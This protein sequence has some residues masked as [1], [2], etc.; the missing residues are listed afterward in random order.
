[1]S[2]ILRDFDCLALR[3]Q[4]LRQGIPKLMKK[5]DLP[6]VTKKIVDCYTEEEVCKMLRVADEDERFLIQFLL[7]TGVRN[8]LATADT[9]TPTN[10]SSVYVA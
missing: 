1:M 4:G 9:T 7:A 3:P 10:P 2:N 6:K 5:G 8:S